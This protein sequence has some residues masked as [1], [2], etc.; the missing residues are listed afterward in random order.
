V[1]LGIE[2]FQSDSPLKETGTLDKNKVRE[3]SGAFRTRTKAIKLPR[4]DKMTYYIDRF[5]LQLCS[6]KSVS[7]STQPELAWC[8]S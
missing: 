3:P 6:V 1:W 2:N 4:T 7:D 5:H 8:D